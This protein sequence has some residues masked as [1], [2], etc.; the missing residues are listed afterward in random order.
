VPECRS[1]REARYPLLVAGTPASSVGAARPVGRPVR[2]PALLVSLFVSLCAG[3]FAALLPVAEAGAAHKSTTTTAPKASTTKPLSKAD[4]WL[5]KALKAEIGVGSVH[6]DG[7]IKQGKRV[8]T[9]HLV[10]NGTGEGGGNFVQQGNKINIL[11]VGPTLYFKAPTA[12]WSKSASPT[13]AQ[14]YGDR[15]IELSALDVRFQSFDQFLDAADVVAAAFQGHTQPLTVGKPTTYA[16]HKVVI[17]K[18]VVHKNGK[19]SKG[20]MYVGAS[21]KAYVYKIVNNTPGNLATLVFSHYSKAVPI[22]VPP[23]AI[24]LT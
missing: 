13:Q 17:I 10:V 20:S 2:S 1:V 11:R 6:I 22:T 8:I 23:N 3:L 19:T 15:W 21:G 7:T 4:Q 9:L 18:D 12:F 14:T 16:G 24:N 5:A